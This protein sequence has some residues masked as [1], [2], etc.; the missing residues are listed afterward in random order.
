[1]G[2]A[3]EAKKAEELAKQHPQQVDEAVKEGEKAAE[4][5]TGHRYDK[6]IGEGGEQVERRFGGQ[7]Q[8]QAGQQDQ[9][10][11]QQPSDSGVGGGQ[12]GS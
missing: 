5:Q 9:Q 7:D 12:P 2:F 4:D 3:D 11:Q 10:Q 6:Q 1:M 8:Q